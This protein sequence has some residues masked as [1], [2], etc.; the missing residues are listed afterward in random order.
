[1]RGIKR[2]LKIVLAILV[3]GL[4]ALLTFGP[5][6][7]ESNLNT[8]EAHAPYPVTPDAQ[9]LHDSLVIGDWHADTLLWN[10]SLLE[11][12][13]RGHVDVPRLQEGNVAL[14]VF[15]TVTKSPA[16]LNYEENST[17]ARDN[18]TLLAYAQLWPRAAWDSLLE[19]ALYQA[20]RLHKYADKAPDD[21]TIITTRSEL[22]SL[23]EK[24]AAGAKTVG[25]LLGTEGAH[26]LEGKIQN[27]AA[28]EAAG[29]RMISLQHFFDNA[30]GGSLHGTADAGLTDFGREVV[31]QVQ[32]RN[33]VLDVSHSS[34][35]VIRD[36]LEITEMPIVVSHTGIFS[37]CQIKR[38][39]PD[40][41]I[42]AVAAKGGTIAIGYWKD[43]T[44]DDTPMGVAKTIKAAIDLVGTDYVSL[45]SDFDGAVGTAFDT[46]ELAALTQA[47]LDLEISETDIRKVM[48]EN[49]VRVL[50]ARLAP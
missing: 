49:M 23:L 10:R 18:I 1:M 19:R 40:D 12:G 24:R 34:Q 47:L 8:V 14:Q 3:V 39:I 46:S 22:D 38:N 21:L 45:G 33:M 4:G 5:G 36:V 11:R 20:S 15:T 30:A 31:A 48:G 41:L 35:Q 44:C 27:I 42:Q 32:A 25:A 29:F 7:L 16:G 43:V 17:S 6:Y 50:R 37:N 2:L 28:L 9:A 13:G 26:P